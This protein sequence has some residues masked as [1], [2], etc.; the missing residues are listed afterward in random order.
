MDS[1]Q[2]THN[3]QLLSFCLD[4]R[5]LQMIGGGRNPELIRCSNR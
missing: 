3:V 2:V 5:C 4:T 1:E